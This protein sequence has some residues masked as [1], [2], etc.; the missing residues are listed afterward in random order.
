MF[1]SQNSSRRVETPA[2]SSAAHDDSSDGGCRSATNTGFFSIL[3]PPGAKR[4]VQ[5][6]APPASGGGCR[7]PRQA[8]RLRDAQGMDELQQAVPD[9]SCPK[10]RG[11]ARQAEMVA[12]V[13]AKLSVNAA[14]R[15]IIQGQN[16]DTF[17]M[18]AQNVG[19]LG[20][21]GRSAIRG[22]TSTFAQTRRR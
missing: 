18:D 15:K 13:V 17:R 16:V 22:R 14:A 20:I 10:R 7:T 1:G 2:L 21:C 9:V 3:A 12:A 11:G 19:K 4:K 5:S 8:S 6:T